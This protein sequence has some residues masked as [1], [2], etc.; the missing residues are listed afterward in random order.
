MSLDFV[1]RHNIYTTAHSYSIPGS[2]LSR[3]ASI[4][5]VAMVNF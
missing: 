4:G 1:L 3:L 5:H 2:L